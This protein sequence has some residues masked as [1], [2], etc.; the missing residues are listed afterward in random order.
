MMLSLDL[1]AVVDGEF[2]DIDA[3]SSTDVVEG[4]SSKQASG[5][6][7]QAKHD[8]LPLD[9][10]GTPEWGTPEGSPPASTRMS[11]VTALD[12]LG[13][14]KR[15]TISPFRDPNFVDRA[16]ILDQ[17]RKRCAEAAGRVALVGLG[18][19]GKSQLAIEFAHQIVEQTAETWV[20]WIHAGTQVRVEEGF[21]AI[22]DAAKLP[23]RDQPGAD[24]PQ[25]VCSWLSNKRSDPWIIILDGADD[26]NVF[27]AGSD[28]RKGKPLASYLPQSPNGSIV[29]T[30]RNRD[31]AYRLTGSHKNTIEVGPM[32]LQDALLLLKK[33][34]G[35]PS[36]PATAKDL[37]QALGCI[38]LAISQ[39]AAYIQTRA[40][41][42]SVEKYLADFRAV[43]VGDRI[44]L[45]AE[46]AARKSHR[47]IPFGRNQNFVA[48][49]SIFTQLETLLPPSAGPKGAALW[50]RGGFGKTQ[51][52]LEYAW[53]RA[54][55]PAC[56]VF[57][58]HAGDE[59]TFAQSYK[60]IAEE[61]GL[62]DFEG[63]RLL[64]E[65]KMRIQAEPCWVLVLDNADS[66][67]LFGV[68]QASTT[69]LRGFIPHA[70]TGTV[71]WISRD[72][73]VGRL[74]GSPQAIK[75]ARMTEEEAII[76][77]QTVQSKVVGDDINDAKAL[78]S[79]LDWLP[80]AI[81][82]AAEY[83][84]ETDTSI[85]E[86][87]P[88]LR[89]G[90]RRWKVLKQAQFGRYRREN[91]PN[92]ILGTWAISIEQIRSESSMAYNILHVQAFLDNENIPFELIQEAATLGD[93]DGAGDEDVRKAVTRLEHFSF[94]TKRPDGFVY[95]MH[96]LVQ[97]AARYSLRREDAAHF[98][99]AAVQ[100]MAGL[101]P[102][103]Q[104]L[105]DACE[106]Y[107]VHAQRTGKWA[108]P[109]GQAAETSA[110]LTRISDYLYDRGRW[111]EKEPVDV[112]AYELRKKALGETHPHTI[113]S[114][115]TLATTYFARGKY[116][117]GEKISIEMLA[118]QRKVL[119]DK[120][121]STIR[122]M[123]GLATA[124]HSQKRYGGAGGV[125]VEVLALRRDVLGDKHP[126]TIQ[127]M[128]ALAATY[129]NQKKYDNAKKINVE[130]LALLREMLG[131]KHAVT[132]WS[133][134]KLATTD[135]SQ[136]KYNVAR[137]ISIEVLALRRG[138]LGERH[139][140][141]IRAMTELAAIYHSQG[142]HDVAEKMH[143]D[144]LALRREV[145]GVNH[146][147]TLLSMHYLAQARYMLGREE[148]AAEMMV[149]CCRQQRVV[150]GADHPHTRESECELR[151]W[152]GA[153]S[154]GAEHIG[155]ERPSGASTILDRF[156][157]VPRFPTK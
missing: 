3:E 30:T 33:K 93:G 85:K 47:V 44:H 103:R 64:E 70:A 51:I 27:Y 152:K 48:R 39:A 128:A 6:R 72:E 53:R 66:L 17:L 38:P 54:E 104:G 21:R 50:G 126:E 94:F 102:E 67:G 2:E 147:D 18:G 106:K 107:L 35:P 84:W 32:D 139:P 134:A 98:A 80:L 28:D 63:E 123:A 61:L 22:A 65:V 62:E 15:S 34:L 149:E 77:L 20:F 42:S 151:S 82:Q 68:G 136:E 127:S 83:L 125:E 16:S 129:H 154:E 155:K 1:M 78:L 81:S 19:I 119:G 99:R 111:R 10:Q 138:V 79:E 100:V 86:Y 46:N 140:D 55:D 49:S 74:V 114:M 43:H 89:D 135:H 37:V 124:Y 157:R 24:I 132:I 7:L 73:M 108:E 97:E 137:E 23:S 156:V 52:A 75:V 142:R 90:K 131:D 122:N 101:F 145:L 87:F 92:S 29:A 31:L 95:D 113:R 4:A 91:V 130:M 118:L 8:D 25:L 141:T 57:W 109:F 12:D 150:L 148:V 115:A 143:Q 144:A 56:S 133:M 59:A 41:I 120:H 71:L 96:K 40:P 153:A 88:K 110:L 117:D 26:G 14:G 11:H 58:V 76:L 112:K 105:W 60:K 36:D 69:S 9:F 13:D 121:P 45:P 5:H 116:G 146:P